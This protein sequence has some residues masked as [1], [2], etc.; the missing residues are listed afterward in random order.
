M[1]IATLGNAAVIHTQRWVETFRA[2]GHEV[3]LWSLEPGPEAIG[4]RPL[5]H[6][7]A[8]GFVRYPLTVPALRDALR[9]F[10]PDVVD[11][12]YV[13]NYGLMGALSGVRPLSVTA[14][15]S[16]LLIAGPRDPLQRIR[17][18]YVLRRAA[19]VLADSENLAA[20]ARALGADPGTVV[21][22]PWGIDVRRFRPAAA[23]EPGLLLSTRMHE[24]VY[25]IA[26]L[27]EGLRPLMAER[28]DLRL[29]LTGEGSQRASLERLAA[30]ALPAGRF[31]FAGRVTAAEMADLLGRADL[32]LS[33]SRSDST[34]V[35]LLEA[36]A[37]GALPVVTDIDGKR[38]WVGDGD[39]AQLFAPGDAGGVT[40]AA[41]RALDDPAWAAAARERNRAVILARGDA[42]ANMARVEA[43]FETL[44]RGEPIDPAAPAREHGGGGAR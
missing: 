6:L 24:P 27:I 36:M 16:D 9:A 3:A 18:R 37:S 32:Y 19:L 44:A 8:P 26:T 30:R 10:R 12:H 4:A 38:E 43:L 2:R 34:S 7:P 23:R 25:D 40:R 39:G 22:L 33:A 35:S 21:A 1:R 31:R 17:T 14:W 5:R 29:V 13:P 28:A 41:R 11:A 42:A 15:G 20:A